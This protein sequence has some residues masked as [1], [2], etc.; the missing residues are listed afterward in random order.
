MFKR[1]SLRDVH[2]RD[3]RKRRQDHYM[4]VGPH[5]FLFETLC[6]F[7][8][9]KFQDLRDSRANPRSLF[10]NC[11]FERIDSLQFHDL[12]RGCSPLPLMLHH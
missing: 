1:F 7:R 5:F 3:Q 8:R 2:T 6:K 4:R 11:L 9:V 10:R 12:T